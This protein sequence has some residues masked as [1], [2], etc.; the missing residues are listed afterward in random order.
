MLRLVARQALLA[1]GRRHRQLR[2]LDLV[3]V[4]AGRRY[5]LSGSSAVRSS[6]AAGGSAAAESG[7]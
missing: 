6:S 1:S 3:E 5:V 7:P 4:G 2:H